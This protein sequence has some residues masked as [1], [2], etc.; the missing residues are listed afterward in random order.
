MWNYLKSDSAM[1]VS[2]TLI[3]LD[4]RYNSLLTSVQPIHCA[5]VPWPPLFNGSDDS[6]C[7]HPRKS[8]LSI[9]AGM[10]APYTIFWI[11]M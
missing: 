3:C 5:T 7:I 10:W 1:M 6:F 11:F 2:V 4:Y 9:K 8:E